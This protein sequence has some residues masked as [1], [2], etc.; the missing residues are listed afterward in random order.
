[1]LVEEIKKAVQVVIGKNLVGFEY[2][3]FI[4]NAHGN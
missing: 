1:M 2:G 3:E 4:S